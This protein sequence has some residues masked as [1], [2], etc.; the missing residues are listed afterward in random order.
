M[1]RLS[2]MTVKTESNPDGDIEI[3]YTGLRPGEKL[4]EELFIG[5]KIS[6]TD[7]PQIMRSDEESATLEEIFLDLEKKIFDLSNLLILGSFFLIVL[8]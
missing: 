1:I 5:D 4:Y 3:V 7:H 8:S 2:G 6:K